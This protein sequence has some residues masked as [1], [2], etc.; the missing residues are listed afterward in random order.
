MRE[1]IRKI[2]REGIQISD[3]APEWVKEFHTLPREGRIS[4][5]EK[6][7]K[8]IQKL[9]PRI[10]EFFEKKFGDDLVYLTIKKQKS[11]YGNESYSTDKIVLDFRFSDKTPNV[12][13]LKREV[14]NDL[15]SFFNIDVTYYGT[16]LDLEFHK[17]VWEKF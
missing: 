12:T 10:V 15:N 8:R 17:A 13:Q 9:L 4:L 6:N 5:I 11:Y 3:D 14:F 16:P 7:K 1:T 2:L